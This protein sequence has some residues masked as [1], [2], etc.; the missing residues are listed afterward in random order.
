VIGSTMP[1]LRRHQLAH[2][3]APGWRTVLDQVWDARSRAC[4]AHWAAHGLPLVVTRQ[5][6]PRPS[7]REPVALGLSAPARW[8]RQSLAMGVPLAHIAWFSEFPTLAEVLVELPLDSR[9]ALHDLDATLRRH[10]LRAHAYG[11]AGWQRLTGLTYRHAR[12]DLDLWMAVDSPAQA[13]TASRLLQACQDR[14]RLDG[15]LVFADGSAIAWREWAAWRDG[16]SAQ[17]LVKRLHGLALEST[18]AALTATG[19]CLA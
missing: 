13:D 18:P 5:P 19:P 1:P 8:A 14:V 11:S 4:L 7:Q 10:G 3:N 15:E 2:L 16:R 6:L 17:V 9:P 12:S